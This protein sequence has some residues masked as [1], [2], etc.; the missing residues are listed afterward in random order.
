MKLVSLALGASLLAL[1]AA[2][3]ANALQPEW[4]VIRWGNG[5]CRIWH[6]VYNGPYGSD[7][8]AV[9]FA[10][11]YPQAWGKMEALYRMRR[12]V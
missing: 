8:K 11:T 7:W 3:P 4:V 6:N 9:A 2:V 5:D 12:C 1:A 10:R